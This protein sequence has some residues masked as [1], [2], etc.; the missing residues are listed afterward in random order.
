MKAR[1][2]N[3][4]VVPQDLFSFAESF[5]SQSSP[6]L[7]SVDHLPMF[8]GQSGPLLLN[9]ASPSQLPSPLKK[10]NGLQGGVHLIL[11]HRDTHILILL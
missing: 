5:I 1:I 4:I 2:A 10:R 3:F 8:Y 9:P 6:N 11:H 7:R